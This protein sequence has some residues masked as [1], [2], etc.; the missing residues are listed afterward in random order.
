MSVRLIPNLPNDAGARSG[1]DRNLAHTG[2][3]E[4]Q[5]ARRKHWN[6]I[7]QDKPPTLG[8]YYNFHVRD[9]YRKLIPAGAAVLEIGCGTGRLLHELRPSVGV[10]VDFSSEAIKVAASTYP[11]LEF[12]CADAHELAL[13]ERRFDF[14]IFSDVINDV[15]DLQTILQSVHSHCKPGTR[16]IFS[17]FSQLWKPTLV[18]ARRMKLARPMMLQNWFTA[19]DLRNLLELTGYESLRA[20][21]EMICPLEIPAISSFANKILTKFPPF[22][23]FGLTNFLIARPAPDP[24][25]AQR[26]G[27]PSVSVVIPAR[28]EAGHIEQLMARVPEMGG[29]TEIIFVEGNSTDNTYDVIVACAKE[30]PSRNCIVLKQSGKGKGDAVRKGFEAASGDILM[31]LDADMTVAPEDLPRFY[32]A[33]ISGRGEFVNGVRLVYP[34]DEQAMR[35]ANLIGNK[36]FSWAFSWLLG[37]KIRDT[38]CGTKVLWTRDYRRLAANRAHF[39]DFDPFGD[40]DLLFGAAK[41]NLKIIEVPI[42]YRA[43]QY[44]TTNIQRWRHGLI[45][46]RMVIFAA[47]RLKFS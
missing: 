17:F 26:G 5:Q 7:V 1:E 41:L 38:L 37:Q 22:I 4:Y 23:L 43:R 15:W 8:G 29:G 32:D 31:I 34:M 12:I 33:L 2:Y 36:F 13:G 19:Q 42:R 46:L 11:E 21:P 3:Y 27:P 24:R 35:L 28:N 25:D 20:W 6:G 45:L 47:K 18:L 10:G 39:G 9:V 44:G 14:I 30:H 40:F 16:L